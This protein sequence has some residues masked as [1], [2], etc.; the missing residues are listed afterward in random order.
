[1]TPDLDLVL[2]GGNI[3]TESGVFRASL[4]IR[5]DQI[6]TIASPQNTVQ[7]EREIDVSDCLVMPG[8]IDAHTHMSLPV[9][10]TT[11][12]D[13]FFTGGRAGAL[14]GV[15]TLIDFTVPSD[16]TS[17]P[18]EIRQRR[19]QASPSPIDYG[20][21]ATCYG[22]TTD[23]ASQVEEALRQGVVSFKFFTTYSDSGR[24]TTDGE[25]V[26]AFRAINNL[27]G[28]AVLHCENDE[29]IN[30]AQRKLKRTGDLSLENHPQ[31]HPS[32]AEEEAISRVIHF[33]NE[34]DV[35]LHIAHVSTAGGVRAVRRAK[36]DG[37][38]VTAE[39]C[40]QYLVLT[41]EK[42]FGPEG[43]YF[44][45][46]PP[47]RT[48]ED[49]Q[50][51]WEG[52]RD[53]VLSFVV[54]DHCPFRKSQKDNYPDDLLS[55]PQGLPGVEVMPSLIYDRGSRRR[56]FSLQRFTELV[57]TNPAKRYNLYPQK[58]SLQV[59]TDADIV[60]FDP[61]QTVRLDAENLHMNVDFSPYQGMETR[62]WPRH[63]LVRGEMVV[64]D[65]K[66]AGQ[67]EYGQWVSADLIP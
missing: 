10:G 54:T 7:A 35:N 18:T 41:E 55:I 2:S 3:V 4:G 40:P 60:V 19:Q 51:L 44:S 28:M 11:S 47:L 53:D 9:A 20:L 37:L 36:A 24:R 30:L 43:H 50:A 56:S 17:I 59:G 62:G 57:S 31:S 39:T 45:V 49:N 13:D 42:F 6:A 16:D 22:F 64:R 21:H 33:A 52:L 32:L 25:L 67:K 8:F 46:T 58:G 34:T 23:M 5:D 38:A 66:F 14:G 48:P 12:S 27:D 63:V 1:M 15:T 26:N 29:I 65:K 61:Q